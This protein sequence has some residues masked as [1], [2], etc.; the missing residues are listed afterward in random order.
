MPSI[1]LSES[2]TEFL[3]SKYAYILGSK[4]VKKGTFERVFLVIKENFLEVKISALSQHST[5]IRLF[6]YNVLEIWIAVPKL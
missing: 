1:V 6:I 5:N 2:R 3:K 4:I